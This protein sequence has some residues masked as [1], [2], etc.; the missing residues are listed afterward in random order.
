MP[1]NRFVLQILD[2]HYNV[3]HLEFIQPYHVDGNCIHEGVK[4]CNCLDDTRFV[5][6]LPSM[7]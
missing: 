6:H 5:M 3:V 2:Y 1:V 7:I 4:I